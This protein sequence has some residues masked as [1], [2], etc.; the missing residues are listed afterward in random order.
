VLSLLIARDLQDF[1]KETVAELERM[2]V[3]RD[4]AVAN[5]LSASRAALRDGDRPLAHR[6]LQ[7]AA[8]LSPYD[9]TI[10]WA[11]LEVVENEQDRVTCLHNVLA[12]NPA[13]LEAKRLLRLSEL[14]ISM[15]DLTPPI[16]AQ[17][18][19]DMPAPGAIRPLSTSKRAVRRPDWRRVLVWSAVLVA[20]LIVIA[21]VINLLLSRP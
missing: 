20:L 4:P 1:R 16:P 12:I 17:Q 14:N 15:I 9:E 11:L 21:I 7:Q 10:W 5:L 6:L 8:E 13:S 2:S 19:S 18:F 3:G